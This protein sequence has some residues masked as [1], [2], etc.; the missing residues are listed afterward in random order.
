MTTCLHSWQ[1][2]PFDFFFALLNGF[3]LKEAHEEEEGRRGG[4][5]VRQLLYECF[6]NS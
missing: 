1:Q 2:F 5:S 4:W 6:R 3:L